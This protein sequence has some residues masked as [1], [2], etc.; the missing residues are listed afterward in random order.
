MKYLLLFT[1]LFIGQ[2]ASA[3]G[4]DQ[5]GPHGGKI[6]MAENVHV[7]V[8]ADEDGSFH[9]FLL[10]GNILNP[11][12]KNSSLKAV[13]KSAQKDMK[14]SCSVMAGTHYHCK[15]NGTRPN[16]GKLYL[17]ANRDGVKVDFEYD[18][19]KLQPSK[20]KSEQ[21]SGHHH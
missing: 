6:E 20:I 14:M 1:T 11:T 5:P 17:K 8:N 15:M 12:V 2:F 10:D 13:I 19:S 18:L 21:K 3:H 16:E 9:I 4:E 7:E